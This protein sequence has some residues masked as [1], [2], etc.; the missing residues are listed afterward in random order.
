M[1]A[2]AAAMRLH[3]YLVA[4]VQTFAL[5]VVGAPRHA[6]SWHRVTYELQPAAR[7]DADPRKEIR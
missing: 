3:G 4:S 2:Y 6:A 7:H 5:P 1:E